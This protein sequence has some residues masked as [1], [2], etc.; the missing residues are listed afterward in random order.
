MLAI[1]IFFIIHPVGFLSPQV[2][3]RKKQHEPMNY[4]SLITED[5]IM[6][7][8]FIDVFSLQHVLYLHLLGSLSICQNL[9]ARK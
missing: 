6:E 1:P 4:Y 9:L 8:A 2:E 3:V 5:V 7:A